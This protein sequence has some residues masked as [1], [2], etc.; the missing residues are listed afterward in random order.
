MVQSW[1]N[2]RTLVSWR[3]TDTEIIAG[4]IMTD[5]YKADTIK[6]DREITEISGEVWIS[7][8]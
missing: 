6:I 8:R 4:T 1:I 5:K 3:A 7:L 2:R